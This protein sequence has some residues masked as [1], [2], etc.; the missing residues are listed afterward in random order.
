MKILHTEASPG[1]GG[2][3]IRTLQEAKGMRRRGHDVILAINKSSPLAEEAC[4][5]GFTV[6]RLSFTKPFPVI[7]LFKL[8]KIIFKHKIEVINTHSSLDAWSAGG[9]ARILGRKVIRTRHLSTRIK[10]GLNGIALYRWLADHV[11]TTS[12]VAADI[13]RKQA[14]LPS[15]RC[16]SIPTGIQPEQLLVSPQ[17]IA[18]FRS[19]WGIKPDDCLA[20]TLCILRSWK[21]VQDL[22]QAAH[23]LRDYP[24][25]KW[26]VVGGGVSEQWL[27]DQYHELGLEDNVI[28]TG[29]IDKPW[30]ALAA[31]DIFLLLSTANEGVSQASLQ[32][33]YFK[34]SLVTTNIGG[35]GEVCLPDITGYQARVSSPE[36]VAQNVLKLYENPHQRTLLGENAHLLVT[37]KFTLEQT[38]NEIEKTYASPR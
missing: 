26:I 20:G 31:M 9:A 18:D 23:M 5:A 2:Q 11:I 6:Y 8:L 24:H 14:H 36:D 25:L 29:Y 34:K 27:L 35:L 30:V 16:H 37:E 17:E 19:H 15:R 13:V 12:E 7:A 4:K 22:L 3:E 1:W 10:G 33:A 28:F 21:G 38:L 32:A